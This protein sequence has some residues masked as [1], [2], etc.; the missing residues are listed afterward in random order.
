[1]RWGWDMWLATWSAYLDKMKTR[2]LDL[3]V[4]LWKLQRL[5]RWSSGFTSLEEYNDVLHACLLFGNHWSSTDFCNIPMRYVPFS[6]FYSWENRGLGRLRNLFNDTKWVNEELGIWARC[7]T[8]TPKTVTLMASLSCLW[9]LTLV[10]QWFTARG[11]RSRWFLLLSDSH[12]CH[13]L[14]T[15]TVT[16]RIWQPN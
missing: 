7:L 9:L 14:S 4:C 15:C 6:P 8:L 12:I 11:L 16:S 13:F 5:L 10:K 3:K 2:V 1:M